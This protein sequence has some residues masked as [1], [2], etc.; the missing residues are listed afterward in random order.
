MLA[1]LEEVFRKQCLPLAAILKERGALGLQRSFRHLPSTWAEYRAPASINEL[2]E[3]PLALLEVE[4]EPGRFADAIVSYWQPGEVA[5]R[6]RAL[7][8][9]LVEI[10]LRYPPAEALEEEVSES[11]YVMF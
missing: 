6:S 9:R 1:E 7:V 10:G 4:P 5:E 3:F 2:F 8:A 11:V